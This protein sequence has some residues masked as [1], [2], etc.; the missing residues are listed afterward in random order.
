MSWKICEEDWSLM[1]KKLLLVGG[2]GHC[3]S[4][5]DSVLA[6]S[7]YSDIGIIDNEE[8]VGKNIFNIPIIGTDKD[9]ERLYNNGYKYAF[10]SIGS[11]GNPDLRI[12]LFHRLVDSGY[13]IPN[14]IDPSSTVSHYAKL[15]AGI[16]IGKKV[17]INSGVNIHKGV[18]INTASVIEHDCIIDEFAHI[19]PGAILCGNIHVG[20]RAHIGAGCSIRQQIIIGS[21]TIIGLG[22]V[23]LNN[24][25][26]N[27]IAYGNPCKGVKKNECLCDS[28]SRSK[29]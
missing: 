21:D 23:V 3:K 26:D 22:S 17:V 28:G 16:F 18:I 14:V 9:L 12:K 11:I 8:N 29:S 15:A 4:V 20:K 1:S 6:S 25:E 24:I 5:L 2:G 10:I 19:A 27:V 7:D 13:I